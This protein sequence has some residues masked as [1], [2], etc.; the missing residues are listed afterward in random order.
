[1]GDF[2]AA[3]GMTDVDGTLEVECVGQS[4]D[5][6]R[7]GVHLVAVD[8]LGRSS[9]SAAVVRDDAIALGQEEQHLRVPVVRA[10]R[11]AMVK[12]QRLRILRAQVLEENA[13]PI[14]RLDRVHGVG[15]KG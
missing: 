6:G 12:Y 7:V 11:P 13:D 14:L 3:G 1:M 10:Q 5:I 4:R 2:T 9:V 15:S 8:G